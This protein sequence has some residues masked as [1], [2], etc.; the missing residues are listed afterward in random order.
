MALVSHEEL[1]LLAQLEGDLETEFSNH[2]ALNPCKVAALASYKSL[3]DYAW[4]DLA[5]NIQG[6]DPVHAMHIGEVALEM[7]HRQF[8]QQLGEPEDA[9]SVLARNQYEENPY[10]RW[11]DTRLPHQTDSVT[12]VM[13]SIGI[14]FTPELMPSS[15]NPRILVA[16]VAPDSKPSSLLPDSGTAMSWLLI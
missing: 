16:G 5:A 2:A 3:N 13:Q 8:F 7:S 9:V 4:K 14:R 6:M 1:S 15:Q 12:D 10:L 11:V